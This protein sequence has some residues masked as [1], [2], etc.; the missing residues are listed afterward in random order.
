MVGGR[1]KH[2]GGGMNVTVYDRL[3]SVVVLTLA[4]RALSTVPNHEGCICG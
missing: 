4:L 1:L 2:G 3:F